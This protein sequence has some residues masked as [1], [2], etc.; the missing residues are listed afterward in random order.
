V[1]HDHT[2]SNAARVATRIVGV[3]QSKL[4]TPSILRIPILQP[5]PRKLIQW[6]ADGAASQT[7]PLR[8]ILF[9]LL[10]IASTKVEG[11][12]WK[13]LSSLPESAHLSESSLARS[14]IFRRRSWRHRGSRVIKRAGID[15]ASVDECIMGNVVS[16]GL[17]QNPARQAAIFGGLPPE[18]SAFTINKVCGSG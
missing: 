6:I 17:G 16:A 9:C 18:I 5:L 15:P 3:S 13:T 8:R 4:L 2:A 10:R 1:V 11:T 7:Q 14:A 12:V